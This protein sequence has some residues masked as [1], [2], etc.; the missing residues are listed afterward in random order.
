MLHC[1]FA[2][3]VSLHCKCVCISKFCIAIIFDIAIN[4]HKTSKIA[5]SEKSNDTEYL[6]VGLGK[7]I[8]DNIK[9][10]YGSNIDLKNNF[11]PYYDTFGLE[12]FDECSR[13]NI[14]YSN[15]RYSDNYNTSPE[16]LISISF[17]MDYLGFFGYQQ[18]TNLFFQEP[19]TFDY[20]L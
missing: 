5:F 10:S 19:G 16:E 20:G 12:I 4:Y 3:Q 17:Y 18:T 11:S 1:I 7:E 15:R 8:N 13:L 2:L 9:I 6:G 14:Q